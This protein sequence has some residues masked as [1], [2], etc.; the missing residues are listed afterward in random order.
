MLRKFVIAF[1]LVLLPGVAAAQQHAHGAHA[2]AKPA[3]HMNFARELI[4]AKADLKL[5]AEQ[6]QKLEAI[7]V[8]MDE[9][10]KKMEQQPANAGAHAAHG[11]ATTDEHSKLHTEVLKVFTEEQ[12]VKVRP[13]MRAHMEKA[14]HMKSDSKEK[15]HQH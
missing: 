5:T 1:A 13:M 6:I 12:L 2:A 14:G 15:A 8:K 7:S 10:H 9:M 4:A 3:E 11:A